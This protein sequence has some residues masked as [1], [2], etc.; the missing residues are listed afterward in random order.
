MSRRGLAK[1]FQK[2]LGMGLGSYLRQVR[3]EH[4]KR[5]LV[6]NDL[7]LNEIARRCGYR[8]VNSFCVAFQRQMCIAPMQFQRQYLLAA[9]QFLTQS[10]SIAFPLN[11]HNNQ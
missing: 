10:A 11:R 4:A 5:L 7:R 1:A 2:N 3:L 9:C 6:N 8:S